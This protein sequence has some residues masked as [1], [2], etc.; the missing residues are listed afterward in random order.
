M[1]VDEVRLFVVRRLWKTFSGFVKDA[2]EVSLRSLLFE[3]DSD[4]ARL[5]R[6]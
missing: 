1:D 2:M 5:F 4:G 3:V 6:G